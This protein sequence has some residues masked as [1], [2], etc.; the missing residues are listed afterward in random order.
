MALVV[1][2]L[3]AGLFWGDWI[4]GFFY[5]SIIR[6]VFVHHST[7]MVNSL[8]HY[9]G[10][11][12]FA[13][14]HTPRDSIITAFLTLGE[15]YHNF[16]HEFP[17]DYRNAIRFY[18]YDPTKWLIRAMSFIGQTY[19]LKTFPDNE[20][21]KGQLQMRQKK[22]DKMKQKVDWGLSEEDLPMISKETF[23]EMLE[24]GFKLVVINGL[25]HD[26]SEFVDDHPGGRVILDSM[27]GKDA[28][29][30]FNGGVYSHS[31]AA[32][33]LLSQMRV[34]RMVKDMDSKKFD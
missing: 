22:L 33:N 6:L 21:T 34:G 3:V 25:V 24:E 4:G 10:S 31:N 27:V 23:N 16:H 2:T 13:D 28:T 5:S 7:F 11:A 30:Q 15:G 8:A 9:L 12:P 18:Q 32:H 14:N 19:D 1:P 29:S 17:H 20:V 26:A